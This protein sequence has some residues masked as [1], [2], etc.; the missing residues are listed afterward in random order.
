MRLNHNMFSLKIYNRYKDSLVQG[1]SSMQRISSGLGINLAKDNLNKIASNELLKIQ[2]LSNSAAQ[3]NI[4]D[5]NSM[6]QTFDS[7]I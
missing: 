1:K 3:R 7:S 6:L 5:T 2:I 4:Q